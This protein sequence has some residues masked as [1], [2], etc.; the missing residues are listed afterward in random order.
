MPTPTITDEEQLVRE[1]RGIPAE[2]WPD[3]LQVIREFR[4]RVS[5]SPDEEEPLPDPLES[6]R[7]GWHEAMTGQT[8]PISELWKRVESE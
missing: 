4:S 6:F 2:H 5:D 7:Q 1:I 8:R 3:L